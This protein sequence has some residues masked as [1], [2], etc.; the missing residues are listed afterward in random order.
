MTQKGKLP[1][2]G[3]ITL[4]SNPEQWKLLVSRLIPRVNS[5]GIIDEKYKVRL[6]IEYIISPEL[7]RVRNIE[8]P[9]KDQL[10]D[11][12]DLKAFDRICSFADDA[13]RKTTW[14]MYATIVGPSTRVPIM[15]LHFERFNLSA[16]TQKISEEEKAKFFPVTPEQKN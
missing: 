7:L 6:E 14:L 11:S 10:L 13:M 12:A 1:I 16:Y 9:N 5:I 3:F 2:T 4:D 15:I 8:H